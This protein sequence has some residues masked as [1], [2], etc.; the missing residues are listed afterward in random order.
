MWARPI[1]MFLE[2]VEH[3]SVVVPRFQLI[4]TKDMSP[5]YQEKI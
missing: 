5:F 3:D 4:E 2:N 1:K